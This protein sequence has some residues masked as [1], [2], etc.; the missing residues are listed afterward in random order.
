MSATVSNAGA[1][2]TA[3]TVIV[4]DCSVLLLADCP[5]SAVTVIV[6]TPFASA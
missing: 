4:N 3:F 6:A 2:L 1:S 5:S